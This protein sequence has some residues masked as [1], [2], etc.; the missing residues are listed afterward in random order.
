MALIRAI[1]RKA[2]LEWEWID[3]VPKV[4]LYREA[5]GAFGGST[6]SRRARCCRN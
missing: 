3:R 2:A 1:L 4:T 5:S 6:L